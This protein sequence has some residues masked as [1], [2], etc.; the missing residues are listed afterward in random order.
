MKTKNYFSISSFFTF[1]LLV[2]VIML[3]PAWSSRVSAQTSEAYAVLDAKGTLTFKY[4]ATKPKDAYGMDYHVYSGQQVPAWYNKRFNIKKVVFEKS[5]AQARPVNCSFWFK[6]ASSLSNIE[7]IENLNTESVTN[8]AYMFDSCRKLLGLDVSGFNTANVTD[9]K[10]MFNNCEQLP[11]LDVSKFNTGNVTNM[12]CMFYGCSKLTSLDVSN[13]NTQKV[14]ITNS[15]FFSCSGLTALDLSNFDTENVTDMSYMFANCSALTSLNLANFNTQKVKTMTQ[16]F[17]RC[18][19]LTSLDVSGFGTQ[20]VENMEK[21]FYYCSNLTSLDLSGFTTQKVKN[22][23][24]MFSHCSGITSLDL[25]SFNTGSVTDMSY[26]FYNCSAI[27]LLNLSGFDTQKVTNMN[28]MFSTCPNLATIYAGYR[29]VTSSVRTCKDMFSG[30]TSLKG[31]IEFDANSISKDYANYTTG[32]FKKIV[33]RYGN[34]MIGAAG[35]NLEVEDLKIANDDDFV[36][37]EPFKALNVSYERSVSSESKWGTLCLPFAFATNKEYDF[38][39]INAIDEDKASVTLTGYDENTEIPAGTPLLFKL[40]EGVSELKLSAEEV[41]IEPDAKSVIISED[42]SCKLVGLFVKKDFSDEE[43]HCFIL[44]DDKL[45]NPKKCLEVD[46]DSNV[47]A[48]PFSAYLAVNNAEPTQSA[49]MY[50]LHID[51]IVTVINQLNAVTD[52]KAEYYD[53][54]GRRINNL[55]KGVNIVKRGNKTMKVIMK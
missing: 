47:S 31:A 17:N 20:N 36:L 24:Y 46:Q 8:M 53:L 33:G 52:G 11:V 9:M 32:Y 4:D 21:M 15:M 50:S 34:E 10:N 41:Q 35:K 3:V 42:E 7:G 51:G 18:V 1:L 43:N 48:Y 23:N 55:Q 44:K 29:F 14:T 37:Y 19:K 27:T 26:M 39:S 38:Y 6:Q 30:S 5:F 2:V 22:M 13:F 28:K 54:Q 16:M 49:K 45:M 40:K 25:S 12:K